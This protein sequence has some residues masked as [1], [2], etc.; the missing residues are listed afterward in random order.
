MKS[1]FIILLLAAMLAGF[2]PVMAQTISST[3]SRSLP[4]KQETDDPEPL[5]VVLEGELSFGALTVGG[6]SGS[7][8][9]TP[10]GSRIPSGGVSGIYSSFSEG[11]FSVYGAP[12]TLVTIQLPAGASLD[13]GT[14]SMSVGD[15]LTDTPLTTTLDENGKA[16][17][18]LGGR[19]NVPAG[20]ESG[21]YS[22]YILIMVNY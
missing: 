5:E 22:G 19:L 2:V 6:T 8:L 14:S 12:N 16:T 11:R 13:S 7:L 4:G 9:I 1:S 17:W 10:E 20:Q 18:K 3:I 15:L 21:V